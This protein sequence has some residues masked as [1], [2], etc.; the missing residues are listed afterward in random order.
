M[1]WDFSGGDGV[2]RMR[3]NETCLLVTVAVH[4]GEH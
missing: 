4:S 2:G 1:K 3:R